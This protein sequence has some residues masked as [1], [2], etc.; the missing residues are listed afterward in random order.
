M[1]TEMKKGT[2]LIVEDEE[3]I[4]MGL[5]DLFEGEGYTVCVA[6]DGIEALEVFERTRPS[7]V[8][9]DIM[10]P[11]L[12][13]YDVCKELRKK[14]ETTPILMLTA[15]GQEVDKVLGLELGADDYIVKPFGVNEL[16][17][18]VRAALRRA[19][20]SPR[21]KDESA[22]V[23]GDIR[24]EP[25]LL[26][27][28]KNGKKFAVSKREVELLRFFQAHSGKVLDRN[29]ILDE[30]WGMRY[31]GTT[32]TLDQHIAKLRKKIEDVPSNPQYIVTEHGVGY[33]FVPGDERH[34]R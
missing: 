7:L 17:A 33:R 34:I 1:M 5:T 20:T 9:L 31:G 16:L 12:S 30:V 26:Q 21:R 28:E 25:N 24:V 8:L 27:G 6:N 10:I 22:I 13:G 3:S 18:R 15:K 29:V 11:S 23:F 4:L 2:I 19:Y 32:R 14:D